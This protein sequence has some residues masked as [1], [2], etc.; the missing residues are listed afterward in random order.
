MRLLKFAQRYTVPS[1]RSRELGPPGRHERDVCGDASRHRSY[2]WRMGGTWHGYDDD[3]WGL[4]FM[5][6][7]S[8]AHAIPDVEGFEAEPSQRRSSGGRGLSDYGHRT[9]SAS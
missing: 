8:A 7:P 5:S 2:R 9:R 4:L 1:S 6:L 3:S